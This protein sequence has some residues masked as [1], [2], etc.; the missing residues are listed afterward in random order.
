MELPTWKGAYC[1]RRVNPLSVG[2]FNHARGVHYID[3]LASRAS[4]DPPKCPNGS[5]E[6]LLTLDHIVA[7]RDLAISTINTHT[8]SQGRGDSTSCHHLAAVPQ[9]APL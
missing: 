1:L 7:I 4:P 8:I 6:S 5:W 3:L 9:V 2:L